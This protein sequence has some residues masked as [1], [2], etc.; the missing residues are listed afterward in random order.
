MKVLVLYNYSDNEVVEKKDPS[1]KFVKECAFAVKEVLEDSKHQIKINPLKDN[2]QSLKS[3]IE[4]LSN[5]DFNIV[6]NL[7]E[8]F[9]WDSSM[10]HNVAGIFELLK[11]NFTGSNSVTLAS[12]LN[13]GRTKE[14]LTFY[15]IKT[16][17]FQVLSSPSEE[18]RGTL[19]PPFIIKPLM[20]DASIGIRDDSVIYE[21]SLFKSRVSSFFE[22]YKEPALIE[23]YIDGREFNVAVLGNS[24]TEVL[25]IS[26]IDFSGLPKGMNKVCTYESK[27]YKESIAYQKTPPVC[28]AEVDQKLEKKIKSVAAK[29]YRA[30]GCRDYAR[31][32]MRLSVDG[33]L[34]VIEVNPNPDLSTD[35][36]FAN[37]ARAAGMSYKE[38]ISKILNLALIRY[39]GQS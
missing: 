28:P 4:L 38:L 36:G 27:W 29:A 14:V 19:K 39:N 24:Q 15:G 10:E 1:E 13:K 26:E 25:P 8:G 17:D 5:G 22:K 37:I 30:M 35:A 7:C 32:D 18:I 3:L 31:I 2:I 9:G 20:E 6:F 34:Y 11:I 21:S 33:T 12:C 23:E 16:P